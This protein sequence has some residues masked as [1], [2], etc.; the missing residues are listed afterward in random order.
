M[1]NRGVLNMGRK[2]GIRQRLTLASTTALLLLLFADAGCAGTMQGQILD[3]QTG[4]PIA[5]AVVLGVWTKVVGFP[6]LQHHELVDVREAEAD[7]DGRFSLERPTSF[8]NEEAVTIYKFGYVAWSNLFTFPTSPLHEGEDARIPPRILLARFPAGQ[9]HQRH[10]HFIRNA[11]RSVMYGDEKVP[12]F[13]D[14]LRPELN[15]R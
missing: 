8:G 4:Q 7:A 10:L 6:G 15:V 1:E 13:M 2:S 14:A 5:G 12:K 3:A 9:S 11:R